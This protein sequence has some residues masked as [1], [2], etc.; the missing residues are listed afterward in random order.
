MQCGSQT[1][2]SEYIWIWIWQTLQC[3]LVFFEPVQCLASDSQSIGVVIAKAV[4]SVTVIEV[5]G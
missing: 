2:D 1:G 5:H 4:Q 3:L